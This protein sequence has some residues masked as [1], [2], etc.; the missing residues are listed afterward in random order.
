MQVAIILLGEN[1]VFRLDIISSYVY[2]VLS[3]LIRLS[4]SVE[5]LKGLRLP[6]G[7]ANFSGSSFLF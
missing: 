1:E 2:S 3:D 6:E 7:L 4:F 5:G